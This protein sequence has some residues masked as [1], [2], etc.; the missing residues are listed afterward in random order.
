MW[1]YIGVFLLII[2]ISVYV[3]LI[4]PTQWLKVER[5]KWNGT[6]GGRRVLQISD[7]HMK[8]LRVSSNRIKKVIMK[9][10]PDYIF[11]T[12][13]FVDYTQEELV[14]LEKLLLKIKETKVEMLAVLGNHDRYINVEPLEQLLARLEI[15]LLKNGYIEKEDMIIV[16]IDDFGH[17][18]HDIDKSFNFD[19]PK[20]KDVLVM[21]H[22]PNIVPHIQYPYN[23]LF[24]GHLHGRQINIP[25]LFKYMKKSSWDE[26]AVFSGKHNT[27]FGD[28]Y[29]SKGIGQTKLN[30]RFWVRSE[31]TV[32]Y[33]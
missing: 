30:I 31:V 14:S 16:G 23:A 13:D 21:A 12:G 5:V 8:N 28:Y 4:L 27:Q 32:H 6:A 24:S 22:D 7:I 19:N 17:G 25:L 1:I 3:F 29:I 11:L 9:H 26:G 18:Y 15:K 33:I 10:E 2:A 20:D